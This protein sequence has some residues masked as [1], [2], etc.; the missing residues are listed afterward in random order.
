[1]LESK[2]RSNLTKTLK[3]Q[4]ALVYPL[5]QP[6]DQKYAPPSGWPDLMVIH[7]RWHGLIECKG[8]HTKVQPLQEFIHKE[9]HKRRP[10]EV[11]VVRDLGGSQVE[12]TWPEGFHESWRCHMTELLILLQKTLQGNAHSS[13]SSGPQLNA[14]DEQGSDRCPDP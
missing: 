8:E 14:D 1:M 6:A 2:F 9:I 5:V 13:N 7:R 10:G 11:V 12:V 4:G 3:A